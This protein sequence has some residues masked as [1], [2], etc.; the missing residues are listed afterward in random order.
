[1]LGELN[2]VL[3][4]N[5]HLVVSV[6]DQGFVDS[7][8]Y[9]KFV[10]QNKLVPM[11]VEKLDRGRF[12]DNFQTVRSDSE[13]KSLFKD[14]SFKILDH[15]KY[16]SAQTISTWDI[17][18]RPFSPYLIRMQ[19]KLSSE[20]LLEIKSDWIEEITPIAFEYFQGEALRE[21]QTGT[22]FNLYHLEKVS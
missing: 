13:W 18:L 9:G 15:K 14:N 20:D 17:G 19:Q 2:R 4:Y 22:G 10:K 6:L 16:L 12:H 21:K 8:L 5:G 3:T 1:M 7:S 11:Y